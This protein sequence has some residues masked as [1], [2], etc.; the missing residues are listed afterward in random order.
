MEETVLPDNVVLGPAEGEDLELEAAEPEEYCEELQGYWYNRFVKSFVKRP[1]QH[2]CEVGRT[3]TGKTQFLYWLVDLMRAHAPNESI[4]W[5]DLGK[6]AEILT[7][8]HYFGG[9]KIWTLPG[10]DVVV[11]SD[12]EYDIEY[13]RV[14]TCKGL[15]HQKLE[16]DRIHVASFEPFILNPV[17]YTKQTSDLFVR[18]VY[19]AHR[20]TV[21]RPLCLIFDEFHNVA[22]AA[23]YGF[24]GD[25]SAAAAQYQ[26]CNYIKRN[27]Q[28]LRSQGIR[29]VAT[30]H[31]WS[32]LYRG[33]RTSFEWLVPRRGSKFMQDEPRLMDFNPRWA[34]METEHAYIAFPNRMY[35]GPLRLPYYLDGGKLGRV[36]YEGISGEEEAKY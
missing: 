35:G 36:K 26:A 12:E 22:P 17:E 7:L 32:Q 2:L 3:G 21:R 29:L 30:T 24:A 28:K 4:L 15:W 14:L 11:Q 34:R 25:R 27:V 20:E 19:A 8:A 23:G 16:P 13:G 5:F 6:G 1:G 18:L 9:L 10:C 31:E 33:V